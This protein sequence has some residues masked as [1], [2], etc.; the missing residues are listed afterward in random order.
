[1]QG[2]SVNL[3]V[4]N[5]SKKKNE[6]G[7]VFHEKNRTRW[8]QEDENIFDIMQ[9]VS[10]NLALKTIPKRKMESGQV[11]TLICGAKRKKT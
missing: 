4:K 11:F 3:L 2:V 9:G 8:Q 10:I 7:Q 1:M 6:S 5:N